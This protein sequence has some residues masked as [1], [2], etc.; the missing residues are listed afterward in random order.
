LDCTYIF[1]WFY[2]TREEC[3]NSYASSE[4]RIDGILDAAYGE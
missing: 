2:D 1:S 4:A 3:P